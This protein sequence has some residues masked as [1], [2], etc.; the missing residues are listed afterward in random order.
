MISI[1]LIGIGVFFLVEEGT[2]S[3]LVGKNLV[4]V[5]IAILIAGIALFITALTGIIGA[6]GNFW[7]L[8]ATVSHDYCKHS[9]LSVILNECHCC[10]VILCCYILS[11]T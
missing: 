7:C 11:F 8:L 10:V 3:I 1:G 6:V 2:V 5:A 4:A 9:I